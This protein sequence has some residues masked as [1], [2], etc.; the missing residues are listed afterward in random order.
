MING[1]F[2]GKIHYF[3]GHFHYQ[4]LYMTVENEVYLFLGEWANLTLRP[5]LMQSL[6]LGACIISRSL[7]GDGGQRPGDYSRF[8]IHMN[9]YDGY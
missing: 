2:I 6:P 8:T 9:S 1:G 7:S 3:Y 4:N 5:R